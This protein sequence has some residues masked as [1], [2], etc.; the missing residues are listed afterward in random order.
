[1]QLYDRGRGEG[2]ERWGVEEVGSRKWDG[3]GV[4]V[5]GSRPFWLG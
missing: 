5:G 3:G 4:G 1:M 2:G